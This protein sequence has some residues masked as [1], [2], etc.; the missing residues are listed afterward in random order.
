[1]RLREPSTWRIIALVLGLLLATAMVDGCNVA[2]TTLTARCGFVVTSPDD[3]RVCA[4]DPSS[5]KPIIKT[6]TCAGSDGSQY[7]NFTYMPSFRW[8]HASLAT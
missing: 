7:S 6:D 8:R 3:K 1:M 4:Y 5:C 2:K